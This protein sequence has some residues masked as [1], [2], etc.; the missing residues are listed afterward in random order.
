MVDPEIGV[1]LEKNSLSVK[2]YGYQFVR[3]CGYGMKASLYINEAI[4]TVTDRHVKTGE[5]LVLLKGLYYMVMEWGLECYKEE[6]M[7]NHED[8]KSWLLTLWWL[9]LDK[10]DVKEVLADQRTEVRVLV[11]DFGRF[12]W[13]I[14]FGKFPET[15]FRFFSTL[16][17]ELM[18]IQ[19]FRL[20]N[21][22]NNVVHGS[23]QGETCTSFP[24]MVET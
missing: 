11:V 15:R 9:G 18:E 1:E 24:Y 10:P 3:A 16:L 21:A 22:L 12:N 17:E 8:R 23:L 20:S 7:L 4:S 6:W 2:E 19:S 14:F 5:V 13:D